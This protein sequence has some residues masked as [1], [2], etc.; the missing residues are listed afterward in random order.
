MSR[1]GA[2]EIRVRLLLDRLDARPFGHPETH[3]MNDASPP[4]GRPRDW[5]DDILDAT[6]TPPPP[7]PSAPSSPPPDPGP[8]PAATPP[9]PQPWYS[10][11]KQPPSQPAP[12]PPPAQIPGV[13]PGV[14]ITFTP[15]PAP[16]AVPANGQEHRARARRWLLVHGAAAG[17]GW[18]F[19]LYHSIDAFLGTLG[20]GAPA[21][22]LALAAFS[23]IGAGLVTERIVSRY[24]PTDQLRAAAAW[25]CRIPFATALLVTALH[26]PNPVF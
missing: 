3:L 15:P 25:A 18:T 22:G 2:D 5:L 14:H 10:I 6:P 7:S 9:P 23:W 21:A 1:Q 8:P 26:A 19:G 24:V 11:G 17:V 4:P 12:P 20:P 13:P 16:A